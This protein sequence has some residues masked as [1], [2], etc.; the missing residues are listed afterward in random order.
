LVK[1]EYIC[2]PGKNSKVVIEDV[3]LEIKEKSTMILGFAGNGLLGPII[4]STIIDQLPDIKR[5]GFITSKF[6]PPISFF[7]EGKLEHPF[8][9]YYSQKYNIIIGT[10]E[11]N[12][13]KSSDYNDLAKTICNWLLSEDVNA[14]EIVMFQ[15]IPKKKVTKKYPVYYA[16]E[17]NMVDFLEN[18]KIHKVKK[19]IILG[20]EASLINEVLTNKLK[21]YTLFTPIYKIPSFKGATSIIRV[22]N[23]IY[24]LNI[25]T[26]N[27]IEKEKKNETLMLE[28]AKIIKQKKDKKRPKEL[29]EEASSIYR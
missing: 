15:G 1:K 4:V 6:L 2:P 29:S 24:G 10:C 3:S 25:E 13:R 12:F 7:Y 11:A 5:I 19:G 20:P 22:L 17:E 21:I 26:K 27:F 9:L 16:A 18:Y 28:F 14:K 8:R 23:E